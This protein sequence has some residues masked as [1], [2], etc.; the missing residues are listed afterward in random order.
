MFFT[1]E[2]LLAS[3]RPDGTQFHW[4]GTVKKSKRSKTIF[5]NSEYL[6]FIFKH[7]PSASR[8]SVTLAFS[9]FYPSIF[10]NQSRL[11]LQSRGSAGAR[12][13][14]HGAKAEFHP[15][16]A[17]TLLQGHIERKNPFTPFYRYFPLDM[18]LFGLSEEV[19][20]FCHL[21]EIRLCV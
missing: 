8:Q 21:L 16:R 13:S 2:R 10:Y 6:Y 17:A 3:T 9:H 15:G 18:F 7:F 14:C 4:H 12:P 1:H 20:V 19:G 11:R 5:N